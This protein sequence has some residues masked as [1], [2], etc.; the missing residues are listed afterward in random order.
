MPSPWNRVHP[1]FGFSLSA[2][3]PLRLAG[4]ILSALFFLG[5]VSLAVFGAF[6]VMGRYGIGPFVEMAVREKDFSSVALGAAVSDVFGVLLWF[7]IRKQWRN[8]AAELPGIEGR[9]QELSEEN[10]YTD[11]GRGYY[12]RAVIGGKEYCLPH[13]LKKI[14]KTGMALKISLWAGSEEVRAVWVAW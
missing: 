14:L 6:V 9:I 5:L 2:G 11:G 8:I 12:M 10:D 7:S 13:H 4:I 3:K 1:R